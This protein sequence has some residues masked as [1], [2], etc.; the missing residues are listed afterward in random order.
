M[1]I[2]FSCPC[3]QSF[4]VKDEF[5]GKKTKCPACKA[6]LL[7]PQPATDEDAAFQMLAADGDSIPV[8]ADP[9]RRDPDPEAIRPPN[10][11]APSP[12]K[13]PKSLPRESDEQG[14]GRKP[15]RRDE[16]LDGLSESS[17]DC[18]SDGRTCHPALT[19][20]TY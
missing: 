4:T 18:E 7:V 14:E 8:T 11:P 19:G 17:T 3:G 6:A 2:E 13:R 16:P 20:W 12:P 9:P 10:R 5:A 1:P 15:D